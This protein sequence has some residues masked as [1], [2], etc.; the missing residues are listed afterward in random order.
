M[1]LLGA[2]WGG[3]GS[4]HQDG[5]LY[6]YRRPS[7]ESVLQ[8]MMGTGSVCFMRPSFARALVVLGEGDGVRI[9]S[10]FYECNNEH[11]PCKSSA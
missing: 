7:R 1:G 9:L 3:G 6:I 5:A 11:P 10:A 2:A 4:S 8:V